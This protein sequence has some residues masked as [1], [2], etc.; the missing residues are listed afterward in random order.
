MSIPR[1]SGK[2]YKP[3]DLIGN[4]E[5]LVHCI[6]NEFKS[7]F[8]DNC[9]KRS[10]QLKKCSK[11]NQMYYCDKEC[12]QNDWKCH[13]F[14]CK[15]MRNPLWKFKPLEDPPKLYMRWWLSYDCDPSFASTKHPTLE[16]TEVCLNDI[17]VK[18][19]KMLLKKD[20]MEE[21]FHTFRLYGLKIDRK[22]FIKWFGLTQMTASLIV[23]NISYD[24]RQPIDEML[25]E[26]GLVFIFQ[27]SK[28]NHSSRGERVLVKTNGRARKR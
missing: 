23:S 28:A 4:F 1:E 13:K 7:Q 5:S 18:P 3:G 16:G 17:T 20:V 9:R 26:V 12:Q 14:E 25:Q 11:C 10:D 6:K 8:C 19:E 15:V 2:D 21:L 27:V 22:K 24:V